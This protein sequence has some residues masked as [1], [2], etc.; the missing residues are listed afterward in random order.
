ML[1]W[2]DRDMAEAVLANHKD[3]WELKSASAVQKLGIELPSGI[4]DESR[5]APSLVKAKE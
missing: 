2:K 1:K 4:V 3:A 5:S